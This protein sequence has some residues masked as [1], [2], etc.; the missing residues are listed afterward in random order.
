MDVSRLE[1]KIGRD[2]CNGAEIWVYAGIRSCLTF[3][4]MLEFRLADQSQNKRHR[5]VKSLEVKHRISNAVL[6]LLPLNIALWNSAF[7]NTSRP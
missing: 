3:H 2:I 1:R 7:K 5:D 6:T 4:D